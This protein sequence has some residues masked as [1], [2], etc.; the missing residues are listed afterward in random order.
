MVKLGINII[1]SMPMQEVIDTAVA[2][3][4]LGYEYLML[5]DEGFMQDSYVALGALAQATTTMQLGPCTNGYTRHP[6]VTAAAMASLNELS[7][8]RAFITLIAGGSVVLGPMNIPRQAPLAVLRDTVEIMRRLWTGEAVTWQGERFA[9]TDARLTMG[10]QD[11]PVWVAPRGDK[12]CELAGEI[13]DAAMLMVKA[14]LPAGFG[15]VASGSTRSGRRPLR[16]YI[17][18]IAYTPEAIAATASFFPNVVV[19]TPARQLRGFLSEEQI[20]EIQA[21][22]KTGGSAAAEKLITLEMLQGYKIAGTPA[23]CSRIFRSLVDQNQLD[24]YILNIVAGSFSSNLRLMEDTLKIIQ[25]AE[26]YSVTS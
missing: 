26:N 14:D 17:D 10:P 16:A 19:D 12:M 24:V 8:G 22:V 21:A 11:I 2:A 6:A 18:R 1:P 25:D 23:E 20:A 5:A 9:L 4:Q 3:E 13:G 15:L 7:G